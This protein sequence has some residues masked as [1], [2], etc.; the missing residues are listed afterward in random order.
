MSRWL[1]A[2]QYYVISYHSK[3]NV[4]K[5]LLVKLERHGRWVLTGKGYQDDHPYPNP[6]IPIPDTHAGMA[7]PCIC[8][9]ADMVLNGLMVMLDPFNEI[10]SGISKMSELLP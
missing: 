8:L 6:L 5:N 3:F 10:G 1:R 2:I 4:N 7:N 9:L